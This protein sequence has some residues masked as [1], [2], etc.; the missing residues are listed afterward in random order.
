MARSDVEFE[1]LRDEFKAENPEL[2]EFGNY[3]ENYFNRCYENV[4]RPTLVSKGGL[5]VINALLCRNYVVH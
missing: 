2:F 3:M 1:H 4:V 5:K